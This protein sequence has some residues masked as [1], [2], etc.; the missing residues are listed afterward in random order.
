[1]LTHS[2]EEW[3]KPCEISQEGEVPVWGAVLPVL[4]WDRHWCPVGAAA[5]RQT[6]DIWLLASLLCCT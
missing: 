3:K 4:C 5:A 1:M 2:L 6:E